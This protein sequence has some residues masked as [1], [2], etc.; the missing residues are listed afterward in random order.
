MQVVTQSVF[1]HMNRFS[2][3]TCIFLNIISNF[4]FAS[5]NQFLLRSSMERSVDIREELFVLHSARKVFRSGHN[6]FL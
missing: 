2:V 4:N 1:K 3:T 6:S 5:D